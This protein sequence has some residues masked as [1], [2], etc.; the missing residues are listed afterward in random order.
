MPVIEFNEAT[1]QYHVYKART[2][3]WDKGKWAHDFN[4]LC[5]HVG[6]SEFGPVQDCSGHFIF[7]ENAIN[8]AFDKMTELWVE[9]KAAGFKGVVHA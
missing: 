1:K 4:G 9:W 6:V 3:E 5:P 2:V 8:D 7:G